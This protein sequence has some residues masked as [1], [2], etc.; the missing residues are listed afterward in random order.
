MSK[1]EIFNEKRMNRCGKIMQQITNNWV[2]TKR[3]TFVVRATDS[4]HGITLD[5][6]RTRYFSVG[7]GDEL[8]DIPFHDML[9][10]FSMLEQQGEALKNRKN[11]SAKAFSVQFKIST[12]F[13]D[14]EAVRLLSKL[15]IETPFDDGPYMRIQSEIVRRDEIDDGSDSDEQS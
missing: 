10:V 2:R 7:I 5:E 4:I 14:E 3:F 1:S 11:K 12:E 9:V 6:L 13:P 15:R 8:T